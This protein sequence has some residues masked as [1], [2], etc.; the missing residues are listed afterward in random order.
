M[1]FLTH[2]GAVQASLASTGFAVLDGCVPS[3]VA[4]ACVLEGQ[5]LRGAMKQGEISHGDS[6]GAQKRGRGDMIHYLKQQQ[7]QQQQKG[8]GAAAGAAVSAGAQPASPQ[9]PALAAVAS[10]LE[11]LSAELAPL[12]DECGVGRSDRKACMVAWYPGDGSGYVRHRDSRCDG[13]RVRGTCTG[14]V[15]SMVLCRYSAGQGRMGRA[16]ALC[17]ACMLKKHTCSVRADGVSVVS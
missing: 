11:L 5:G 6:Q 12:C 15:T 16:Y 17:V 3:A 9:T 13:V 14:N 4:E 1:D 10:A 2:A 7:Q 8:G